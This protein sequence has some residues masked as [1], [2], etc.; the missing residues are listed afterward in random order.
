MR[1]WIIYSKIYEDLI[2]ELVNACPQP[3]IMNDNELNS[4]LKF[5]QIHYINANKRVALTHG[6]IKCLSLDSSGVRGPTYRELI[7]VWV[8]RSCTLSKVWQSIYT[9]LHSLNQPFFSSYSDLYNIQH[10]FSHFVLVLFSLKISN[11]IYMDILSA[12]MC[13]APHACLVPKEAK[14]GLRSLRTWVLSLRCQRWVC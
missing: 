9:W 10:P 7:N 8:H 6:I 2:E 13:G 5:Y 3:Y 1:W 12:Y 14:R 11:D 4:I